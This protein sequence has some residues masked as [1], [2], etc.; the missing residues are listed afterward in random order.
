MTETTKKHIS[1]PP[2][3]TDGEIA[4]ITGKPVPDSAFI[5]VLF[6]GEAE[7]IAT[8]KALGAQY[9]YGNLISHL[10]QAWSDHLVAQGIDRQAADYG[11]R[12]ICA[13]C[14]TDSRTG[15]KVERA[16]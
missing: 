12:I 11:G 7:A 3:L 16:K 5:P 6:P 15:Q 2:H 10:Q 9:G 14:D 4:G 1:K 13:W 8:V